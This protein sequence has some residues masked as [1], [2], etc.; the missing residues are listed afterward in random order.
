MPQS[1]RGVRSN[2]FLLLENLI[3]LKLLVLFEW[4]CVSSSSSSSGSSSS[5]SSSKSVTPTNILLHMLFVH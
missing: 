4:H 1:G 3:V 2:L 5:N